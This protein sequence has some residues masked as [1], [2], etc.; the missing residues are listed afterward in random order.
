M[1]NARMVISLF[2]NHLVGQELFAPNAVVE[3]S[4][5]LRRSFCTN[6]YPCIAL[7]YDES[8][9]SVDKGAYEQIC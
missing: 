6:K 4:I 2:T 5:V 9:G 1:N 7:H 3:L 8:S